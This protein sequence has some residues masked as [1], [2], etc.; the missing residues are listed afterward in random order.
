MC[1]GD[2][3][4]E[5]ESN[6]LVIFRH[7]F[8]FCIPEHAIAPCPPCRQGG[9]TSYDLSTE[10]LTEELKHFIAESIGSVE[11]L[12]ILLHLFGIAPQGATAESIAKDLYLAPESV[13]RRLEEFY[14]RRLVARTGGGESAAYTFQPADKRY[15]PIVRDLALMYKERR[16]AVIN[17][18]F[19][20]PQDHIRTFSDAFKFKK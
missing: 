10:G 4:S 8:I 20:T 1:I 19:S 14:D 12:E 17:A 5:A 9:K 3:G 2:F 6:N 7:R 16:V 18:I 11:Q 15:E 13:Q